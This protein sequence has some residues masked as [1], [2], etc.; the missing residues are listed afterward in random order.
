MC[1]VLFTSYPMVPRCRI[2]SERAR[3]SAAR[4][5]LGPASHPLRTSSTTKSPG[6]QV[7]TV[8]REIA[9]PPTCI[10]ACA[11]HTLRTWINPGAI[12]SLSASCTHHSQDFWSSAVVVGDG[13]RSMRWDGV[14]GPGLSSHSYGS[15]VMWGCSYDYFSHWL[16]MGMC[17]GV[18]VT[19]WGMPG[20]HTPLVT[21]TFPRI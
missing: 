17:W 8:E 20:V 16:F 18:V 11:L 13:P 15:V 6:C 1:F 19:L 14:W 3:H 7:T 10:K 4:V 21:N 2:F 5:Y 12:I 9:L